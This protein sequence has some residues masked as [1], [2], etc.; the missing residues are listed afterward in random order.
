[1]G[2]SKAELQSF[3]DVEVPDLLAIQKWLADN[4]VLDAETPDEMFEPFSGKG[5]WRGRL[6][7]G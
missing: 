6:S 5:L 4:E 3:R 2:F 1:M 7:P